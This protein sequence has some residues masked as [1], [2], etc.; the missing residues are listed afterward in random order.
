MT[1]RTLFWSL[2]CTLETA[3]V[4]VCVCVSVCRCVVCVCG[5][6]VLCMCLCVCVCV[7]CVRVVCE[8]VWVCVWCVCVCVCARAHAHINL[9]RCTQ[10]RYVGEWRAYIVPSILVF[11]ILCKWV[12]TFTPQPLYS[13]RRFP[14]CVHWIAGWMSPRGGL[15]LWKHET[16]LVAGNK[17]TAIRQPTNRQPS[18]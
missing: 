3:C 8:C 1:C 14:W 7:V 2:S 5:V 10:L 11:D 17:R 4:N 9:P 6:C 12:F 15:M 13:Q 18:R 16:Y